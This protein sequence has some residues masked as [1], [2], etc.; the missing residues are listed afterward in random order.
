MTAINQAAL[1]SL[2]LL[3]EF[4][5][6]TIMSPG[7][8]TLLKVWVQKVSVLNYMGQGQKKNN[9]WI[10]KSVHLIERW[11]PYFNSPNRN[12]FM[13]CMSLVGVSEEGWMEEGW[14][15]LGGFAVETTKGGSWKAKKKCDQTKRNQPEGVLKAVILFQTTI[16]DIWCH[17]FREETERDKIV[18]I[19]FLV[20]RERY[21][22]AKL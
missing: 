11:I 18:L 17:S 6:A 7:T 4:K 8:G 14:M 16:L 20:K 10:L 19:G 9:L 1:G 15:K 2:V 5:V 12:T 3:S 13:S 22:K 21:Q